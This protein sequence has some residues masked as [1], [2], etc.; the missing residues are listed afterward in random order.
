MALVEAGRYSDSFEAGMAKARLEAQGIMAFLFGLDSNPI[1]AG[2][3]FNIRLMVDEDDLAD[4]R[5]LLSAEGES[6]SG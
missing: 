2:G 3:I 6:G 4:A 1:F 5:R